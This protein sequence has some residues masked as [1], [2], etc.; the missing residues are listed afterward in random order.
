VSIFC[1][2]SRNRWYDALKW[3]KDLDNDWERPGAAAPPRPTTPCRPMRPGGRF[4]PLLISVRSPGDRRR[5]ER[6]HSQRNRLLVE[7]A[8]FKGLSR[9]RDQPWGFLVSGAEPAQLANVLSAGWT[10]V[11]RPW[12]PWAMLR[13]TPIHRLL[14]LA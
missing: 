1:G 7:A 13:Q 4:Q 12:W 5:L 6:F 10:W 14:R 2:W 9:C 11:I 3:A 8:F